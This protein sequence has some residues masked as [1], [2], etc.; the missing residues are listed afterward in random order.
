MLAAVFARYD[1]AGVLAWDNNEIR[2]SL[3]WRTQQ[4]G[5][6]NTVP[7]LLPQG[8]DVVWPSLAQN[9]FVNTRTVAT[10]TKIVGPSAFSE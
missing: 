8:E 9:D 1:G 4:S 6:S 10:V 3:A 7:E 2:G 5:N